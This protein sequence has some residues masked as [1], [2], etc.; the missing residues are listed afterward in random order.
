MFASTKGA[1]SCNKFILLSSS[2]NNMATAASRGDRGD[3]GEFPGLPQSSYVWY[4]HQYFCPYCDKKM[5]S[6]EAEAERHVMRHHSGTPDFQV[7]ADWHSKNDGSGKPKWLICG[8]CYGAHPLRGK[9][10]FTEQQI[11]ERH[12]CRP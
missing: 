12:L 1:H 8:Q 7:G 2:F 10:S 5:M 9:R 3:G 11:K 6:T 4:P